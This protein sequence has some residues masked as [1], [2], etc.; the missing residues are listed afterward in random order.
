M[1]IAAKPK[2]LHWLILLTAIVTLIS[3]IITLRY[4]QQPLLESYAF[5]QTQTA[6]TAYWLLRDGFHF[7]YETPVLGAPWSIPFEFP[8]YQCA[9][10]SIVRM[11]G[12]AL[13]AAGRL[14]S[15]LFLLAC[16]PPAFQIARRLKLGAQTP[17]VF[18]CLLLSSPQYLFWGRTFMVE[19]AAIF[20]VFA[21]LPHAIDLFAPQ[22]R[23]RATLTCALF[24]TLAILQK[25]TTAA[26]VLLVLGIIGL[27]HYRQNRARHFSDLL[28]AAIAF[29]LPLLFGIAWV[30]YTDAIKLA[31]PMGPQITSSALSDWNYGTWQQ[32]FS[33]HAY[34][35]I[36]LRALPNIGGWFGV[37]LIA[38]AIIG[39]KKLHTQ[40]NVLIAV[41]LFSAPLLIFT[42]LHLEHDYYQV[43]CMVYL[44]G[45]LA[46]A[47]SMWAPVALGFAATA[48]LLTMLLVTSNLIAFQQIY[49]AVIRAQF[50]PDN[51]RVLA[52]AKVLRERTAPAS[53]VMIFGDE[54]NSAISY[55][56]ERKSFT[57]PDYF[58]HY[59]EA[60]QT[61]QQFLGNTP[62]SAIV[63]CK[64][65]KV[66]SDEEVFKRLHNEP[67]WQLIDTRQ[68]HILL[69]VAN[70]GVA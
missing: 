41:A 46:I 8:L 57:V 69:R 62:L 35:E 31:N 45:A 23:W 10:V 30:L 25:I 14:A 55:Y 3:A 13:D 33:S 54:W 66:P 22:P 6:L 19:T 27:V 12:L 34:R 53:A 65:L 44:I 39:G 2:L 5:R 63:V 58:F 20:C 59:R 21:A 61:P 56:A 29:A 70:K 26:P 64:D 24:F 37:A 51:E 9:V 1:P 60:W 36:I 67:G 49:G 50:S 15:Y 42:N 47:V 4:L 68:C 17:W 52:V 32:R 18:C 7:A 16:C 40:R 28:R 38:G 11:T 43:A 48:P